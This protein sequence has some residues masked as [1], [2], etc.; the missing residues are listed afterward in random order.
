MFI[1][2]HSWDTG[3]SLSN[4]IKTDGDVTDDLHI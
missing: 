4:E 3:S 1:S 2:N